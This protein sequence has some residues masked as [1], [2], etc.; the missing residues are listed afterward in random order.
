[1]KSPLQIKFVYKV[2][3]V[4][5][6]YIKWLWRGGIS[7]GP[8]VLVKSEWRESGRVLLHELE[9]SKQAYTI[10][11]F[12][13][14]ALYLCVKQYRLYCELAAYAKQVL[15]HPEADRPYAIKA[16]AGFLAERYRLNLSIEEAASKIESAIN[17]TK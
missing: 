14:F 6:I 3:P 16:Y 4:L 11:L 5:V 12:W 15:A 2:L 17:I 10:L 1:L 13:H 7:L 8:V 9:H